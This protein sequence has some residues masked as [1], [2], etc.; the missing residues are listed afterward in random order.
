MAAD[1]AAFGGPF[2]TVLLLNT[3]HYL[4]FGS[5]LD[6]PGAQHHEEIFGWLGGVCADRLIFA[7]PLEL[8]ECPSRVQAAAANDPRGRHY[9]RADFLSAARAFF[10]VR[11]VGRSGGRPIFLMRRLG[12]PAPSPQAQQPGE[13]EEGKE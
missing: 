5:Q 4:Y 1:P 9:T 6:P 3:Y 11:E 12:R 10:D 8:E 7:S 2:E 13:A